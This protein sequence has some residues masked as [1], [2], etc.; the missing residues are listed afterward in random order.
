MLDKKLTNVNLNN[1]IKAQALLKII[2]NKQ[3]LLILCKL[4]QKESSVNELSEFLNLSQ[5][6]TSQHL[7]LMRKEGLVS[8]RQSQ[9]S[10]YYAINSSAV[11]DIIEVLYKHYCQ[12][13]C[14]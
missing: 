2:A 13:D 1:V 12:E 10:I 4:K 8:T 11:G 3:R 9:Q 5:P 14:N 7:A 6:A